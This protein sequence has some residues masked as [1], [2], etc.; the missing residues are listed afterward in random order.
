[1][2]WLLDFGIAPKFSGDLTVDRPQFC[3][4]CLWDFSP[5]CGIPKLP[6]SQM[7]FSSARGLVFVCAFRQFRHR[8]SSE[9]LPPFWLGGNGVVGPIGADPDDDFP[10]LHGC[11]SASFTPPTA[12]L[13]SL[14]GPC[15]RLVDLLERPVASRCHRGW[16]CRAKKAD[17]DGKNSRHALSV[18]RDARQQS[19]SFAR[20][21]RR[22]TSSDNF[23]F[24]QI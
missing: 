14:S 22:Q 21:N 19:T 23:F 4:L 12:W 1:M 9:K 11:G 15:L 16:R 17:P 13:Q 20:W 2:V 8:A 10:I 5:T 24:A 7:T 6:G 3:R 18:A